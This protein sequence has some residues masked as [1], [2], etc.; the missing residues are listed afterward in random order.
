MNAIKTLIFIIVAPGSV[1]VLLPYLIL[2]GDPAVA[3][4]PLISM[5]SLAWIPILC[6]IVINLFCAYEFVFTGRGT[7]APIDPPKELVA[8]GPYRYTRNPMYVGVSLILFSEAW[9]FDSVDSLVYAATVLICFHLFI[10]FYEEPTLRGKF[11][12]SYERYCK[13]VPRWLVKL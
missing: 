3:F 13:E 11:G 7:P 9:L 10:L 5:R 8:K 4:P 12:E 2:S 6:G 1:T